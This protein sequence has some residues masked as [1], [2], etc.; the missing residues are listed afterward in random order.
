MVITEAA[1][2]SLLSSSFETAFQVIIATFM[3]EMPD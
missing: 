3:I 1:S 2:T